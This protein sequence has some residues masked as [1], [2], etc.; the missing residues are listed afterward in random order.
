MAARTPKRNATPRRVVQLIGG[1]RHVVVRRGGRRRRNEAVHGTG[2]A[3]E[4]G[5]D[6]ELAGHVSDVDAERRGAPCAVRHDRL[7]TVA[8]SQGDEA[9]AAPARRDGMLLDRPLQ[10]RRRNGEET[11]APRHAKL[12][13]ADAVSYRLRLLLPSPAW[14][15]WR[16]RRRAPQDK[17]GPHITGG[18]GPD[19]PTRFRHLPQ[20]LA[21]LG[22]TPRL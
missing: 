22:Q 2:A 9:L 6:D 16:R 15:R 18:L 12:C 11:R 7:R 21:G 8:A 3:D 1:D 17:N 5:L 20:L 4:L 19:N 14:M 10:R 13:H